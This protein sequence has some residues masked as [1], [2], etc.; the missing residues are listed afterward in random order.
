MFH[1]RTNGGR[2]GKLCK[3]E[4]GLGRSKKRKCCG[5]RKIHY[6]GSRSTRTARLVSRI[7]VIATVGFHLVSDSGI[8]NAQER[9]SPVRLPCI[10]LKC[11]RDPA[12]SITTAWVGTGKGEVSEPAVLAGSRPIQPRP[13]SRGSQKDAGEA[14]GL[15][16]EGRDK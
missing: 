16:V 12:P 3:D 4:P 10:A 9:R 11:P 15:D 13:K 14:A 2:H 8:V 6:R 7:A 1:I 5:S